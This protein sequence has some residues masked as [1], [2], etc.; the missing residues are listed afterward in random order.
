MI[1]IV[2]PRLLRVASFRFAAFYVAV[3]A[4]SALV[5]GVAVFF[6]ARSALQQQMTARIETEVAFL[7]VEFQSGGLAHLIDIVRKRG[8]GASALDYLVQDQAGAHLAGEVPATPGLTPGW[9]RIEV[10]QAS[11]DGGRPERVRALVSD[12]GD[13]VL[14]AVGGDLQQIDNLE[15]AI[16]TAFLWTIGLAAMLGIVGGVLLSRAFLRR[17]DA[18][19]R[20]AEAIIDG[21]LTR[22]VP[23]RG[24]GDDLD[25]LAGTL[26]HML[27]RIG[28]LM[29]SLRQVS[30]DVAH[31]LRT[32]LTRLYQ[33]LEGARAHA[34]SMAEY[35]AAIDAATGEAQRLLDIFPLCC[36]SPRLKARR[37]A[38]GLAMSI[39]LPS[40]KPSPMRIGRMRKRRV[41]R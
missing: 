7:G 14:L 37:R 2:L 30:S 29:E 20:T 27:D 31:D 35:E 19:S 26:N 21:D 32:P 40:P 10:P 36:G 15:K 4:G 11:E 8:Q 38:P 18:I 33:R 12:L 22:R 1:R 9:T 17:V 16:A 34:Q 13:G 25:R 6:E 3:F 28:I 41:T 39:S 23:T 24:T 5:L